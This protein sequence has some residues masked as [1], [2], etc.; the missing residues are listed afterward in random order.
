MAFILKDG[1]QVRTVIVNK[2]SAT[3]IPAGDFAGM[4][5]G[6]AVDA[7]A[8]TT[9]IAWCPE[10]AVAGETTCELTVGN[11]FT[12][13]GTGDAAFAVAQKGTEVD[14]TAAQLID[15]GSSATDVLLID[16]SED[17]GT[18]GSISDIVVRINDGKN[19]F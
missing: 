19:L 8:T 10:G 12:L 17:A 16:I 15:V 14:L 9:K 7:D 11:D 5:A 18:V 1:E 2:A 6:L 4:T 3:V 13:K